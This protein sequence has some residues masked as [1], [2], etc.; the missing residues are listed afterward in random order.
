MNGPRAPATEKG[1]LLPQTSKNRSLQQ[2]S[3]RMSQTKTKSS[4]IQ[5]RNGPPR[6]QKFDEVRRNHV[7]IDEEETKSSV[8][9]VSSLHAAAT[10]SSRSTD[11]SGACQMDDGFRIEL[12]P[13]ER[14]QEP[15][16]EQE[17]GFGEPLRRH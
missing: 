15:Q 9:S 16:Q 1:E 5:H 8:A 17:Q 12:R 11:R 7:N 2:F 6:R 10:R 3:Y 14:L 13:G 4:D